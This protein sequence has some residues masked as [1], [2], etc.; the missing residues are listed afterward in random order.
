LPTLQQIVRVLRA[1]RV[2]KPWDA[3]RLRVLRH[4]KWRK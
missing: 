1:K 3:V 2:K 4:L